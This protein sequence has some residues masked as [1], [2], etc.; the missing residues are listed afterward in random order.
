MKRVF[1]TM[2]FLLLS[3]IV[4]L[5][6]MSTVDGQL[7]QNEELGFKVV[8]P[9]AWT[10][11]DDNPSDGLVCFRSP[12]LQKELDAGKIRRIANFVVRV[13]DSLEGVED[14][15][16]GISMEAWIDRE[17][18]EQR[19]SNKE[20]IDIGEKKGFSVEVGPFF[21]DGSEDKIIW[22]ENGDKIYEIS[23]LDTG[24]EIASVEEVS[25]FLNSFGFMR[26]D[27]PSIN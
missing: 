19:F 10:V 24:N 14:Y 4:S 16:D 27:H 9:E 8:Y 22:V 6:A 15:T 13:L 23:I 2:F 11:F 17:I 5:Q 12:F 18:S 26:Q 3:F 25:R 7:Y 20:P 1:G 21:S